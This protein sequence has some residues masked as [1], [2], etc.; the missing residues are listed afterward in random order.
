[1]TEYW[2]KDLFDRNNNWQGLE[3]TIR[4][5]QGVAQAMDMLSGHHGRMALQLHGETLFW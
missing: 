3:F 2:W 5:H 1:M 4:A